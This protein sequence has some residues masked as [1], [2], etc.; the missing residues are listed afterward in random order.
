MDWHLLCAVSFVSI[1]PIVIAFE[2]FQ[3]DFVS[4]LTRGAVKD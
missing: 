3:R 2:F 4:G 1:I